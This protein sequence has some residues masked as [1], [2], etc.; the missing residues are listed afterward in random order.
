MPTAP[1][2]PSATD[3][4]ARAVVKS[5]VSVGYTLLVALAAAAVVASAGVVDASLLAGSLVASLALLVALAL[6]VE[7]LRLSTLRVLLTGFAATEGVFW[8]FVAQRADARALAG[9]ALA[10]AAV[11]GACA[12]WGHLTRRDLTGWDVFLFQS[13]VGLLLASGLV[14]AAGGSV[15][16]LAVSAA[17][18]LLFGAYTAHDVNSVRRAARYCDTEEELSRLALLG[19]VSLYL[20]LANLFAD[21]LRAMG[22][23]GRDAAEAAGDAAGWVARAVLSVFRIAGDALGGW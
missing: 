20:D 16:V 2:A 7:R 14:L 5:L 15:A 3:P 22:R 23:A 19:A 6:G 12:A 18:V 17:G 8:A 4:A 11:F 21:L 10:A 13:L 1:S 9:A